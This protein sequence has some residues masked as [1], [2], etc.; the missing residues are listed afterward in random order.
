VSPIGTTKIKRKEEEVKK[1]QVR[2]T[3]PVK[4][5]SVFRPLYTNLCTQI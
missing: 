1:L 3:G 2:K 5:T 4:L